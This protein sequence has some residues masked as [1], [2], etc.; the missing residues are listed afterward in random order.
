MTPYELLLG[1]TP[2]IGFMRPFG[3]HVTILNTLDPL[4]KFN[5]KTDDG[6]LVR[7]SV[8]S[9][10]FRVFNS[11]TRV[12]QETLHINFLENQPN[13]AGSGPTWLFDIDTLTKSMNYQP[14]IAG[15]QPNPSADPQNT[16]ADTTFEVKEPESAVYVSPSSCEKTKKHDDKT[17]SEAKGKSPVEL[18]IGV[19]NLSKEF[20]D[21]SNNS[22]NGVNAA[23][24][25]VTT[26]GQIST[27]STNTF[28]AASPSN[29]A[30]SPTLRKSSY[31]DPSQYP[32]DPNMPALEDITYSDDE[33]D[34]APQT[35]SMTGMVNKQGRL[36][37][38]NNDD[39]HTCMFSCFLSQ[40]KPKR[41][42]QALKDPSWIEAMQEEL[43]QFKM[44]KVW[45]LVDFPKVVKAIYGLNQAPRAWYETLANY[46]LENGFQIGLQVKQKQDGIFISQDKYVAENLRKFGLTD[47]KSSSTPIDTEKPLLKDPNGEDMD[48]HTYISTIGYLMYLTSSRPDIMFAVYT[49]A[50]FCIT[51]KA[52]HLHVFKRIFRYLKGKP[53]LGLWYPKDSP[54][55]LVAYSDSD[56]AGASLNRK[57]TTGGCQ[58][59]EACCCMFIEDKVYAVKPNL[60][61]L[62]LIETNDVVQLQA[63]IDK[64]KVI[65]T[66]DS[67]R[68][69]LR[70]DDADSI[71]CLPNEEII[72]QLA[73]RGYDKPS[74]KLTF[75]KAF[76]SAQWK[77]LIHT[78]LQCK[79]GKRTDWNE[80]S[81]YMA[82]AVICLATGM[83]VPQQVNDDVADD[84]ADVVADAAEHTLPSTT[85]PP[86]QQKL[87]PS[88]S[89]GMH[90]NR[91]EIAKIDVDEDV[92]LEE[93]AT[94]VHKDADIQGRLEE[95]QA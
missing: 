41:V 12:V 36:T 29:T 58:F 14:V 56:Y 25:P 40:E 38:I 15:N 89:Q 88:T 59:R 81:S 51:Q 5:R 78:I 22:I 11:R 95:S 19:R 3:C 73:R 65:I 45:V 83:L 26:V 17:K 77:F 9:K 1:R 46:L 33:E 7:Y 48:V 76:F 84:V 72:A 52:S 63:L 32:D 27:N 10:A 31:V 16:D 54:F 69:A 93:V 80:F 86:L 79:S 20:K 2:S 82:L 75:Y 85:P 55:N 53:H 42:H 23:S 92:T 47:G 62:V 37:Q 70:L 87:I 50:H 39:F 8:S 67:V 21:F 13:F 71:D 60:V 90:P 49:C 6:F 43:L 24:T 28:S 34:V 91:G 18:S 74:T 64:R 35:K 94:E 4:G 30:V 68:Q 57:S 44:Q 66:E 61:L